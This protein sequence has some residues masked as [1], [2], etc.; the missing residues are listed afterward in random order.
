MR[1]VGDGSTGDLHGRQIEE[2]DEAKEMSYDT[3]EDSEIVE[4]SGD[5][6]ADRLTERRAGIGAEGAI[7][8]K[9]LVDP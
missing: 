1:G 3:A 9:L 6:H 4:R 7:K 2:G 8:P 5:L